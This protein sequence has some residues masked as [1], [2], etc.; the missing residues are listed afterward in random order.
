MT[1]LIRRNMMMAASADEKIIDAVKGGVSGD[2]ANDAALMEVIYAQGWSKSP[3]YMTKREAEAVT[4]IGTVFRENNGIKNFEALSYFT[5][6]TSIPNNAFNHC[7]NLTKINIPIQVTHLGTSSFA[8]SPQLGKIPSH[9][10]TFGNYP[11]QYSVRTSI[12][13]SEIKV[14]STGNIFQYMYRLNKIEIPN[15]IK[16]ISDSAFISCSALTSF[17]VHKDITK[18]GSRPFLNTNGSIRSITVADDNPIYDSRSNCNAIIETATNTLIAGCAKTII[19]DGIKEIREGALQNVGLEQLTIPSSVIKIGGY[20]FSGYKGT[21][22]EFPDTIVSN[23]MQIIDNAPNLQE[24]VVGVNIKNI[25]SYSFYN[26]PKLTKLT[27]KSESV[28]LA[29]SSSLTNTNANVIVYVPSELVTAYQADSF[30][31]KFNI[32][33]IPE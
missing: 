25:Y 23:S 21:F 18:I 26:C 29:N 30:W 1:D 17:H 33:A 10:T 22:V 14:S 28:V 7:S 9:I 20:C 15:Q 5:K 16:E 24:A 4:D 11:F 32:Q 6:I 3:L 27:L 19:P 2:A 12:D 13:I 8:F 31:S